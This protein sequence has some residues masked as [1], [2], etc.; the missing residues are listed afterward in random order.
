MIERQVFGP[1][2]GERLFHALRAPSS[3]IERM[4]EASSGIGL[5]SGI[6]LSKEMKITRENALSIWRGKNP[7]D[8]FLENVLVDDGCWLW[9]GRLGRAGYG[10]IGLGRHGIPVQRFAWMIWRGKIPSGLTID[11]ICFVPNCIRPSHLQLLTHSA[12]ASRKRTML[13]KRCLKGHPRT[14]ENVYLY[15]G[16]R[17][18]KICRYDQQLAWKRRKGLAS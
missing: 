1:D 3:E 10:V 2:I 4:S 17:V 11:H 18:C 14:P 6:S 16:R 7:L 5:D 8:R 12:N 9:T 15:P 13:E